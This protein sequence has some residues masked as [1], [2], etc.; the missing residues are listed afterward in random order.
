MVVHVAG[1]NGKG[2]V[3]AFLRAILEAAGLRVHAYTSPHLVRFSER[4]VVAGREIDE[5]SL[6]EIL[7][8]CEA[9]NAGAPITFFEITTAAAFLAFA[10]TPRRR[11]AA[12]NRPR[13]PP[14]CDQRRGDAGADRDYA[15]LARPSVLPWP[16][17]RGDRRREGWH[18]QAGRRLRLRRPAGRGGA[19][20]PRSRLVDRH[21]A[22]RR[23]AGLVGG[24]SGGRRPH[25][26]RPRRSRF[27]CQLPRSP[28]HISTRTRASPSPVY[29]IWRTCSRWMS[30]P[31]AVAYAA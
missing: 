16:D 18:S 21:T 6:A 4:I 15:D 20:H 10:R 25:L 27:A 12:G 3:V 1:T 31:L 7:E 30:M 14:G 8:E 17:H 13:R 23:G 11:D 9:A 5:A 22:G 24:P 29:A 2:S 28:E 19:G 26:S